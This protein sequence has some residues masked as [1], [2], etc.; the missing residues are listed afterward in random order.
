MGTGIVA[1]RRARTGAR[2][3]RGQWPRARATSARAG[4]R[5]A[6]RAHA[7][8]AAAGRPGCGR[9]SV[10]AA[11]PARRQDRA[12]RSAAA[13]GTPPRRRRP[14]RRCRR[15]RAR[16]DCAP[17]CA[18]RCA[19]TR[20][21]RAP[22]APAPRRARRAPSRSRP[23][24][25]CDAG[26]VHRDGGLDGVGAGAARLAL[27]ERRAGQRGVLQRGVRR[28]LER[29]RDDVDLERGAAAARLGDAE[30]ADDAARRRLVRHREHARARS[31]PLRHREGTSCELRM[32]AQRGGAGEIGHQQAGDA[33]GFAALAHA[34]RSSRRARGGAQAQG[35]DA[36]ERRRALAHH[37]GLDLDLLQQ[38]LRARA[39]AQ[40]GAASRAVPVT[41]RSASTTRLVPLAACEREPPPDGPRAAAR[42]RAPHAP[43]PARSARSR[44]AR[45]AGRRHAPPRA[46]PAVAPRAR[47]RARRP[48]PAPTPDRARRR[49]RSTRCTRRPAWHGPAARARPRCVPT[50]PGRR[51][52]RFRRKR[53][54]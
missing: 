21:P 4:R 47:A 28:L 54:R 13:P 9:R 5:A 45:A 18:P 22:A 50:S 27:C 23:R 52:H 7:G 53:R 17:R 19:T 35:G 43:D 20:P 33:R 14:A 16:R 2:R 1:S 46:R 34:S 51:S 38:R 24:C 10:S 6:R 44:A 25:G 31:W 48:P 15:R 37:L 29:R 26:G 12:R 11:R 32:G 36:L 8:A 40:P 30:T 42:T 3:G 41:R 39:R 49:R